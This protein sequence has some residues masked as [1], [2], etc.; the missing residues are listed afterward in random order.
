M[1]RLSL[2]LGSIIYMAPDIYLL[3]CLC[4]PKIDPPGAWSKNWADE[5][6]GAFDAFVSR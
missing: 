5:S 6:D 1:K 4:Y 3:A 2:I